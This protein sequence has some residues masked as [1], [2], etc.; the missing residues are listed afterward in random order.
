MTVKL[1]HPVLGVCATEI[2]TNKVSANSIIQAW[3][4]KYGKKFYE[5]QVEKI[6]N[7]SNRVKQVYDLITG[8]V[9]DNA[10]AASRAVGMGYDT[11]LVHCNDQLT[12]KYK[13][14]RRFKFFCDVK[15]DNRP[16]AIYSNKN[17]AA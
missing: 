9:Y 3:K 17:F 10:S 13:H 2:T 12:S 7:Q 8:D 1:I 16:P 5:C 4:Y 11:I 14:K 6:Y 15:P